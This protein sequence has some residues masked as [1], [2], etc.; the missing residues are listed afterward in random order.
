MFRADNSNMTTVDPPLTLKTNLP[1]FLQTVK[2]ERFVTVGADNVRRRAENPMIT[3][4]TDAEYACRVY[5][6][7]VDICGNERLALNTGPLKFEYFRQCLAG[8]ARANWDRE[9]ADVGGT[10]EANFTTC[11]TQWFGHYFEPTALHDQKQYLLTATKAYSMTVK[12]TAVRVEQIMRFMHFMPS[13]PAIG[14]DIYSPT[15][16]KMTL[17]RLMRDNWKTNFDASGFTITADAY[18][19]DMLVSY[20]AAQE[21]SERGRSGRGSGSGSGRGRGRGVTRRALHQGGRSAQRFRP[22]GYGQQGQ[23]YLPGGGYGRGYNYGGMNYGG[24]GRG[25]YGGYY[26][27]GQGYEAG[28]GRGAGRGPPVR[29]GPG[30]AGRGRGRGRNRRPP[31]PPHGGRTRSGHAYYG[32]VHNVESFDSGGTSGSGSAADFPEG[33]PGAAAAASTGEEY[34]GEGEYYDENGADN[35]YFD[36]MNY[37]YEA[38]EGYGDY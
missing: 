14:T 29:G 5:E 1:D 24:Y 3:N 16:K 33:D 22:N 31:P 15:E 12:D 25:N 23:G 28:R 36:D 32:E 35:Y 26:N 13:A 9:A 11:V 27:S 2:L 34:Y 21:K 18:T 7:F 17:Y 20:F 8:Q 37:G 10:T 4:E 6:E 19:W 38:A 30:R